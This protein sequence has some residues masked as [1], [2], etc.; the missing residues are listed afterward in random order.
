MKMLY[1]CCK[2]LEIKEVFYIKVVVK[3]FVVCSLCLALVVR[4]EDNSFHYFDKPPSSG[5]C[6][7]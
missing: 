6:I 5:Y 2:E 1:L 4:K 3:W 7:P